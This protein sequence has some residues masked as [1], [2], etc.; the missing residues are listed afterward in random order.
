[1]LGML[2]V[3]W[4]EANQGADRDANVE[5][6]CTLAM[7]FLVFYLAETAFSEEGD[8]QMSGVLAVVA[9]GLVFAS[10]YGQ[11]RIDPGVEHFLHE[12]WGMVG[13]LVNTLIFVMAGIIII[14]NVRVTLDG[15]TRRPMFRTPARPF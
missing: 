8:F 7:P 3:R 2:S 4:L 10:P 13:H 12:F 6:I 9:F 15:T 5:V 14:L 1:V 11:V